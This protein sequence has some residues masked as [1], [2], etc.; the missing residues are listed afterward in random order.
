MWGK[1]G[2][3]L[4]HVKLFAQLCSS[5]C[6][7]Y[8]WISKRQLAQVS[9]VPILHVWTSDRKNS[10]VTHPKSRKQS[11]IWAYHADKAKSFKITFKV[12]V[13]LSIFEHVTQGFSE[14]CPGHCLT[15]TAPHVVAAGD[16][17]W[18]LQ[19]LSAAGPVAGDARAAVLHSI[20]GSCLVSHSPGE[21]C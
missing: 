15:A 6:S 19:E 20:K 1:S 8:Q 5:T 21:Q 18:G 9:C 2:M 13:K 4:T 16:M 10:E 7:V 12:T 3:V 17:S 14:R 11:Y